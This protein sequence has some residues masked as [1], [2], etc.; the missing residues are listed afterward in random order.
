MNIKK[1]LI[2]LSL[3][4][5]SVGYG[6]NIMA[7][8]F[9]G[10]YGGNTNTPIR[11]LAT[12]ATGDFN[13]NG[14][15]N[16]RARFL[17][18]NAEAHFLRLDLANPPGLAG[19]NNQVYAG[20][21]VV[22]FGSATDPDFGLARYN[23]SADALQLTNA[24]GAAS[25]GLAFAPH[26]RKADFLNGADVIGGLAFADVADGFSGSFLFAGSTDGIVRGRLMVQAGG[27][28]YL[29]GSSVSSTGVLS[30]NPV[31]ETWFPI[32][33]DTNL[34]YTEGTDG[35]PLGVGVSGALLMDIQAL[36]LSLMNSTFNGSSIHAANLQTDGFQAVVIPE[37]RAYAAIFGVFV[38]IT[39]LFKRR[40][41]IKPVA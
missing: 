3:L 32:Q 20:A 27:Q 40:M 13:A 36:G 33:A 31:L 41:Q 14:I 11:P 26:V 2:G 35:N 24:A 39:V 38:L 9:G 21:Q 4:L 1:T 8:D 29:S 17:P 34:L 25:M 28:W 5:T 7:V 30:V 37:P 18:M 16:D 15:A 23:G 6:Q 12:F 22:N 10:N 19:K